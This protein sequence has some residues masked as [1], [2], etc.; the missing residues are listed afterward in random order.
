MVVYGT[1]EMNKPY[2]GNSTLLA[3]YTTREAADSHAA[4]LGEN[5]EWVKN[6]SVKEHCVLVI[7]DE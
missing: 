1:Y 6:G 3:L 4:R 5:A 7:S 2:R